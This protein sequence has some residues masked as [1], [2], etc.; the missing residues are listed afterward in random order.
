MI[1]VRRLKYPLFTIPEFDLKA[2]EKLLL[3]G[4]SGCGKTSFLEILT[5]LREAESERLSVVE[6]RSIIHQDLNL[7]EEFSVRENLGIE[8]HGEQVDRAFEILSLLGMDGFEAKLAGKMSRGEKQ[9]VATARALAKS[10]KLLFADEPTSHLD[11]KNAE[12]LIRV[13]TKRAESALVVS[14]DSRI[15]KYFDRVVKFEDIVK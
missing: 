2:G 1:H 10:A 9:R 7:I 5:G 6:D 11:R 12:E 8:L 3:M 4:P 15:E 14:H 13:L